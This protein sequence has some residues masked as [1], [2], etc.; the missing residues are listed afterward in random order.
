MKAWA[1]A[2]LL[3]VLVPTQNPALAWGHIVLDHRNVNLHLDG[4]G[5]R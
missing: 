2:A 1:R 4:E 5:S 3:G